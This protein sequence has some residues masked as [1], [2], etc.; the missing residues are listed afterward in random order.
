[1]QFVCVSDIFGKTRELES[2]ATQISPDAHIVDPYDAQDMTFSC[3][4]EAYQYFSQHIG[5]ATFTTVL[6]EKLKTFNSETL[7]IGFSAGASAIWNVSGNRDLLNISRAVCYYGS[8]IRNN[9]EVTPRF[10]VELVF[11]KMED[12]F[13]IGDLIAKLSDT[14]N[15]SIRQVS[16]LH[17]FMNACSANFNARGYNSELMALKQIVASQQMIKSG[18]AESHAN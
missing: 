16:Y 4:R 11:P 1:M 17:G 18:I 2:L 12:H 3:E 7:L 14:Q 8:Q 10:P 6:K 15:T 13:L 5:L 9:T